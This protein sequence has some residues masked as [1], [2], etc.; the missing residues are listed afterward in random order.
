[1]RT[2]RVECPDWLL[3]LNRRH[4]ERVLRVYERNGPRRIDDRRTKP[5]DVATPS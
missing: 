2:V 5:Y 3:I 1:V 4:L